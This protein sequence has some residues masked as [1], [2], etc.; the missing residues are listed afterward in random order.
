MEV[1]IQS[2]QLWLNFYPEAAEALAVVL[3]NTIDNVAQA[4]TGKC[5]WNRSR[6]HGP[7]YFDATQYFFEDEEWDLLPRDV[8][9]AAIR[10]GYTSEKWGSSEG[11]EDLFPDQDWVGLSPDQRELLRTLGF[12]EA[13]VSV[14]AKM[15]RPPNDCSTYDISQLTYT[16]SS[17]HS[18]FPKKWADRFD[19]ENEVEEE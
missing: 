14:V 16:Y 19:E 13:R 15:R 18:F 6:Y 9:E 17:M 1:S 4:S 8:Q 7:G 2:S 5:G 11:W 12:T 10:L 3:D